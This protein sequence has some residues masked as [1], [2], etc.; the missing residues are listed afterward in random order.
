VACLHHPV[1]VLCCPFKEPFAQFVERTAPL[2]P[3]MTRSKRL[4]EFSQ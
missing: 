2:R 4:K 3:R 1:Q